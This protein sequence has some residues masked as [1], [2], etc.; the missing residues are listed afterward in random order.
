MANRTTVKSNIQTL[1]VASVSNADMEDM[2]NDN[3]CD[4]VQFK[5]HTTRPTIS[6]ATGVFS[7]DF[8]GFDSVI[9]QRTGTDIIITGINNLED[10]QMG[11]MRLTKSVGSDV[12]WT[13]AID[14]TIDQLIVTAASS[15][16]YRITRKGTVYIAEALLNLNITN[17]ILKPE[18]WSTPSLINGH[19]H[20]AGNNLKYR[21]NGLGQLELKGGFNTAFTAST[22]FVLP[23]THRPTETRYFRWSMGA[24]STVDYDNASLQIT[25]SG[26][27]I[28][29]TGNTYPPG[30]DIY[31]ETIITLD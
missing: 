4:N 7:I 9:Y 27:I 24:S 13:T 30:Y 12:S 31:L 16:I 19:I 28:P 22:P 17:D 25:T 26:H 5:E 21:K 20:I 8:N 14:I 29:V 11:Y 1:N 18:G 2:L 3:I 6:P 23:S 10:G 15:I